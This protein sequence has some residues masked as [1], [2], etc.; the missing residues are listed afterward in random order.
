M[1]LTA[2]ETSLNDADYENGTDDYCLPIEEYL[3]RNFGNGTWVLDPYN[4]K[5][6]VWDTS[7]QGP[8]KSYIVI[9][10]DY[11]RFT[12]TVPATCVN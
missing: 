9:D 2:S 4:D 11:R 12:A 3:D 8:E 10:R 5:F 6:V 1:K 7:H